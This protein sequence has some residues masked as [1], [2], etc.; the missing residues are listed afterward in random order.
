VSNRVGYWGALIILLVAIFLRFWALNDLPAGLSDAEINTVRLTETARQGANAINIF[1]ADA[2]GVINEMLYPISL[3]VSTLFTGNGMIGY[4]VVSVW[5]GILT[6][7][8]VYTLAVRLFGRVAGLSA[9]GFM[10]VTFWSVLLSRRITVDMLL[11]LLMVLIMLT[12]ARAIPVYRVERQESLTTAAF[13]ALGITIGLGLYVHPIGLLLAL[14]T[15]VFIVYTLAVRRPIE[16]QR[17]TYIGFALLIV[18][19]LALPYIIFNLN[20]PLLN[21]SA[22]L[23]GAYDGFFNALWRGLQGIVLQGDANPEINLPLRPLID[24]ITAL[25]VVWGLV[26]CLRNI[27]FSRY[28]L[29]LVFIVIVSPYVFL[30]E[31]APNFNGL[32]IWLVPMALLFGI[33]M[34]MLYRVLPHNVKW[35]T[36]VALF[37]LLGFNTV[38]TTQDLFNTWGQDSQV[39]TIYDSELHQLAQYLDRTMATIPTVICYPQFAQTG[40]AE[41]PQTLKMFAMMNRRQLENVRFM[42]CSTTLIL[43]QGGAPQQLIFPDANGYDTMHP[44]LRSWLDNQTE[45]LEN[46]PPQRVYLMDVQ[47]RLAD[48][49]GLFASIQVVGYGF[50]VTQSP[51][52][53]VAPPVRFG[54]NITWMGYEQ[55]QPRDYRV[56][57]MVDIVNFWRVEDGELPTDL[58]FFTHIL[59]DPV[60]I[61]DNRDFIG[62]QVGLL[63]PRDVVI[64]VASIRLQDTLLAGRYNISIG[65]YQN[66]TRARLPVFDDTQIRQGDRL[67][68]Y[69]I[70][71][72]P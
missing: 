66:N 24:P 59:S 10:A 64:Q 28:M 40:S 18:I 70:E 49:L 4:R 3:A 48:R 16:R 51:V 47:Q 5:V 35:L 63:Q 42:D 11:P 20:Q 34:T 69:S 7:A 8:F 6:L 37:I 50:E 36:T 9:M 31:N 53:T 2:Y 45:V 15:M 33:G 17:L 39:E 43:T 68:I 38:W 12:I 22:R 67:I 44:Y 60:T 32:T 13:A 58:F 1:Y 27:R 46:V 72:T 55:N 52:Q 30:R 65:A 71:V 29:I 14:G 19:I 26:M 56:G 21:P 23:V 57:D 25:F 54:G 62:M 41:L 61:A